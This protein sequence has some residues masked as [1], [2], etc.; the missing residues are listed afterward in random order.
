M[1]K[2][3]ET[4][5]RLIA[6]VLL[7]SL[8]LLGSA[9]VQ[10]QL[11][12]EPAALSVVLQQSKTTERTV[13]LSNAGGEAVSF[14][15]SFARPLQRQRGAACLSERATGGACGEIGE[16]L[17]EIDRED[18]AFS[19]D[20]NGLAMTPD[21]RLFTADYSGRHRTVELTPELEVLRYFEHPIVDE[22]DRNPVTLGLTYNP[23]TGSLWWLNV[24]QEGF[25]FHRA[26]LLE[27]DLNGTPTGRRIE[28][29]PLTD[30]TPP[31]TFPPGRLS[32][33]PAT[34][35]YYFSS[36]AAD[37]GSLIWAVDSL[38]A[39]VSGY[40]VEQQAY[41]GGIATGPDAHGGLADDGSPGEAEAVRLE[42]AVAPPG[43]STRLVVVTPEGADLGLETPLPDVS[44]G[45]QFGSITGELL[46]S[47]V[48]PNGVLYFAFVN[49]D[50]AGIV[51]IRPHP[52]PPSW[53]SVSAWN[54]TLGSG[55]STEIT[56]TFEAGT[57]AVGNS[58]AAALQVFDAATGEALEVPLS[59]EVAPGTNAEDDAAALPAEASLAVF[60]NPTVG[61]ATLAVALP[62]RAHLRLAVFDVLGR[63]VARV[64]DGPLPEGE[65][66][67]SLDTAKLPSGVYLLRGET[68]GDTVSQR[69]TVVR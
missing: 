33:D 11:G 16:V 5:S 27:G 55:E 19:W 34:Q 42:L 62:E 45:T 18:V 29:P 15:V 7:G 44:G 24:E 31:E 2:L 53:L 21:G 28:L 56:L 32:Y 51:G 36:L 40:P 57:R 23:D 43:G 8:V 68:D 14:C 64:V 48:D 35:R 49:F 41:P 3:R 61:A 26:L 30:G 25:D 37:G 60:P 58:Y 69:L 38:G 54:G 59:F 4:T 39:L 65:H 10:A 50:T 52:L 22:L 1:K 63:E 12:A 66:A 17:H 47:R 20:P 67:F 6:G 9:A 13:T 46:R